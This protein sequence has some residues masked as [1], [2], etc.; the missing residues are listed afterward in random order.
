MRFM[1]DEHK[2]IILAFLT[3]LAFWLTDVILD[4]SFHKAPYIELV[5]YG[6]SSHDLLMRLI[7]LFL[8]LGSGL[9]S[10]RYVARHRLSEEAV[11]EKSAYLDSI[12]KSAKEYAISTTDSAF[13]IKYYNPVAERLHGYSPNVLGRTVEETGIMACIGGPDMAM[14][15]VMK[16]GDYTCVA[17]RNTPDGTILIESRV[18]GIFD[19]GKLIGFANFSRDITHE[20]AAQAEREKLIHDLTEALAE[21][22]TLSG[23]LPICSYCKKVR[24]DKGYW[25]RIETYISKHSTA[26]FTHSICPDCEKKALED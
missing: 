7:T 18:S 13:R 11:K 17:E 26:E 9:F 14:D 15:A 20:R 22:K 25:N 2:V 21:V 16:N 1:R 6:G 23:L 19:N 8:I 5:L 12:L 3:G 10:A 24:D 4:P